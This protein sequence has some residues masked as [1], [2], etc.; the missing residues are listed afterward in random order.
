VFAV[1]T[2]DVIDLVVLTHVVEHVGA[3]CGDLF[4]AQAPSGLGSWHDLVS[5]RSRCNP[6]GLLFRCGSTAGIRRMGHSCA[7]SVD[8]S[9]ELHLSSIE[10]L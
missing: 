7:R 2:D 4:S 1:V 5:I 6:R 3:G 9:I 10:L 8:R